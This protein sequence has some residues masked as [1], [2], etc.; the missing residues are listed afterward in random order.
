MGV[1]ACQ[2]PHEAPGTPGTISDGRPGLEPRP[3]LSDPR[4][5]PPRNPPSRPA[6]GWTIY[7]LLLAFAASQGEAPARTAVR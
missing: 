3:S 4:P 5:S 1:T 7:L 6:Q 2:D